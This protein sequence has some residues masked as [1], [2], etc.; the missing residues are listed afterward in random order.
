MSLL[1]F[2]VSSPDTHSER[3]LATDL[4][5]LQLKGKLEQVTGIPYQSQTVKLQRT[6]QDAGHGGTGE[7]SGAKEVL[8]VLDEDERT[9]ASYGAREWMTLRVDSSD[10]QVR[11]LA[12]QFS[13]PSQVEKFEL[14]KEEYEARP[15][16]VLAYKQRHKLG[17][18]ADGASSTS[19]AEQ[20]APLDPALVSGA[21]C[22]VSLSPELSRRG[23]VRFVG[24][25]E[26][27]AKDGLTWVGVEW[28]E[29][30]GKGDGSVEGKRYFKTLP[31]RASF[32]RPD[33]VV[34]GDFPEIDPF[35][36]DEDMEM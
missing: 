30:V 2:W 19:I 36:E 7:G 23:T 20:E 14:T 8:A 10:P 27:G 35:A 26:F 1:T 16:T 3:R 29:P 11:S 32:V 24:P 34:V 21:R 5:I 17:R 13:D 28:D 4:T 6:A 9:L 22:E 31:Q 12:G 25:T 33:K 15:D 18:F